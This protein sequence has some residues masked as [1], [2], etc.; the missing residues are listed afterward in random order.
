M[1]VGILNIGRIFQV[2]LGNKLK[3]FICQIWILNYVFRDFSGF[4]LRWKSSNISECSW[5]LSILRPDL[6]TGLNSTVLFL[7]HEYN[8]KTKSWSTR[9]PKS[10]KGE[11]F[12]HTR[13][14]SWIKNQ[15]PKFLHQSTKVWEVFGQY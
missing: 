3:F 1:S 7:T 4:G 8:L 9:T 10:K 2:F 11:F 15:N 13:A 12:Q 14:L 5:W 6:E